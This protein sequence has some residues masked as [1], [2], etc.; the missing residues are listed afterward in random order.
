M[1]V[2]GKNVMF[3]QSGF[4]DGPES[5]SL[6]LECVRDLSFVESLIMICL[7]DMGEQPLWLHPLYR[8]RKWTNWLLKTYKMVKVK[9][10]KT[11][12]WE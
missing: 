11:K 3:G 12:P 6:T 2:S 10:L 1:H 4:G 7:F 5:Y 9:Q 8:L